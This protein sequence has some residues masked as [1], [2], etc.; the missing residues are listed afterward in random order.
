MAPPSFIDRNG[1]IFKILFCAFL[2]LLLMIPA[3]MIESLVSSREIRKHDAVN[4]VASK[5]GS[6]LVVTGPVL[7]IPYTTIATVSNTTVRQNH[8]LHILPSLANFDTRLNPSIR[9]RGIYEVVVYQSDTK[10]TGKYDLSHIQ[11][12]MVSRNATPDFKNTLLSIGL[13]DPKGIESIGK[14]QFAGM[15]HIFSPGIGVRNI[16]PTGVSTPIDITNLLKEVSFESSFAVRGAE[17]VKYI[18][19]GKE[20]NIAVNSSWKS[21]S[22]DGAFLPV[23]REVNDKGFAAKWKIL[24]FNRD[25]PESWD[26]GA[27]SLQYIPTTPS[28]Q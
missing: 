2:G 4:E 6:A 26:D 8:Y 10:L 5:W 25:F 13:S 15:E 23:E 28:Y 7:S 12:M 9:T 22:F 16:L 19:V 1:P 21:P 24:D 20:T 14:I 18:P 27:Y 17:S 11:E 3:S